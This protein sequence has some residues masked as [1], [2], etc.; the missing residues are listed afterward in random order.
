MDTFP[1]MVHAEFRHCSTHIGMTPQYLRIFQN[2]G[3]KIIADV[4]YP[5]IRVIGLNRFQVLKGGA[6][7]T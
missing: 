2:G 1:D 7:D 5:F 4:R 3:D 6:R